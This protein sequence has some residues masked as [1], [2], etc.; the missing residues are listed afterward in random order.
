MGVPYDLFWTLCPDTLK[1]FS[2]A[3]EIK[4][5]MDD[6]SMWRQGVYTR[7]AIASAMD[8]KCKYPE[9]PFIEQAKLNSD[10]KY[11]QNEIKRKFLNQAAN[12]ST[13]NLKLLDE[14]IKKVGD[15]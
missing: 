13:K 14:S 8:K 4:R 11:L 9:R 1:P 7:I 3:F 5:E 12:M 2:R 6:E 10:P 15:F